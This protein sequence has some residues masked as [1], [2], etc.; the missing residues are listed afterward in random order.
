[1][2]KTWLVLDVNYLAHRAMHTTGKLKWAGQATGVTYGLFRDIIQMQEQFGADHIVFCFDHGRGIR[3]TMLKEYKSEREKKKKKWTPEQVQAYKLLEKEI[4]LLKEMYLPF[5]GYE[6]ILYQDGYEADDHIGQFCKT[7]TNIGDIVVVT[8]DKDM[9]Q[10][11]R[12]GVIIYNPTSKQVTTM[13]SF[14]KDWKLNPK[15]W[16]SIKAIAGCA[17]D[18]VPGIPGVGEKTAAKYLRGEMTDKDAKANAKIDDWIFNGGF[19][20]SKELV[21]L[22]LDGCDTHTPIEDE[23]D[24]K[25]WKKFC[26]KLGMK[27]LIDK[28][29]GFGFG[30]AK[31]TIRRAK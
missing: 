26:A 10:V 6:N 5:V 12:E 2:S 29:P 9:Y 23:I 28:I 15:K 8:A 18:Q 16:T 25:R 11:L 27:S 21:T 1:M 17:T 24:P 19:D 4:G 31:G 22:P 7:H 30:I 3:K 13:D 20:K 14:Y